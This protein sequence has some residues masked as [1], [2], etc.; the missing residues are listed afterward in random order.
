MFHTKFGDYRSR[1]LNLN[2]FQLK[3]FLWCQ[4]FKV[5]DPRSFLCEKA[6]VEQ[7][8]SSKKERTWESQFT[9][10]FCLILILSIQSDHVYLYNTINFICKV[11]WTHFYWK[12]NYPCLWLIFN[13]LPF[14]PGLL[15]YF[16]QLPIFLNFIVMFLLKL[17]GFSAFPN[18]FCKK[19]NRKN[20]TP[21]YNVPEKFLNFS[22]S[23]NPEFCLPRHQQLQCSHFFR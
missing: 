20:R 22:N 14:F 15:M 11:F 10:F 13:Q 23:R 18:G 7:H 12:F 6:K 21:D 19:T 16:V 9:C 2:E 4:L 1:P 5:D 17:H 3:N 8:T